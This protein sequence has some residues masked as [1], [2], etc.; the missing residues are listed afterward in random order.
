[1]GSACMISGT[2][3][4][5]LRSAFVVGVGLSARLSGEPRVGDG[6]FSPEILRQIQ[7]NGLVSS[8]ENSAHFC[9]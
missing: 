3:M 2:V 9:T 5:L 1:M 8:G 6:L 7:C 4:G